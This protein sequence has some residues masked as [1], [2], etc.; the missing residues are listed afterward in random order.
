MIEIENLINNLARA[1]EYI[2]MVLDQVLVIHLTNK[3]SK[4]ILCVSEDDFFHVFGPSD[5]FPRIL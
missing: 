4:Y 1:L 5:I 2:S 3:V